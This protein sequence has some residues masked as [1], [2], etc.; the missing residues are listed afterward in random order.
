M[1][2][3]LIK[4]VSF[5][6]AKTQLQ[7]AV[8]GGIRADTLSKFCDAAKGQ[9]RGG[10]QMTAVRRTLGGLAVPSLEPATSLFT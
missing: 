9:A 2:Q 5:R 3:A 6:A 7:A 1:P 4:F 8:S 10:G